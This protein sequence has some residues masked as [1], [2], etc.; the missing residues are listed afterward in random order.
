[1]SSPF[2]GFDWDDGNLAK[3]KKHGLTLDEIERLFHG[4]IHVFPDLA[5]SQSE[6]R[7]IGIG[8]TE[9][10]RH[11]LVS[12]TIRR[13]ADTSVIRPIGARSC[14]PKRS[15]TMKAKRRS[16][17][18]LPKLKSDRSA[19]QF[20]SDADLTYFDLSDMATMKFEFSPKEARINMRL[21]GELLEAVKRAAKRHGVPYQRFIRQTLENA[22]ASHK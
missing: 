2:E 14:T 8:R 16:L 13:V 9:S 10:A 18:K 22:L 1:M 21:P 4:P 5:G 12:F 19:E 3:C 6:T 15:L 17:K 20:V 7:Y 11:V